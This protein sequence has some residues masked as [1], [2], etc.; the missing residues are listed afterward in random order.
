[1]P[2]QDA[3]EKERGRDAIRLHYNGLDFITGGPL[4]YIRMINGVM[5]CPLKAEARQ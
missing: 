5:E 4:H 1:M 3:E 2:F